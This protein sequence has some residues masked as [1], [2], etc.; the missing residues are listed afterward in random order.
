VLAG[1]C[2]ALHFWAW[3]ASLQHTTVMRS[4]VLVCLTPVW[5]GLI[6]WATGQDR[7][8]PMFWGGITIA[9]LGVVGM[10]GATGHGADPSASLFGDGLAL[11]GGMLAA[12][13]LT[14]GRRVRQG[15]GIGPYGAMVTGACALWLLPA[16]AATGAQLIPPHTTAWLVLAA[17]AFG[18]QLMGHIGF[19]YAVRY[20]SAA[21]VGAVVL[22]EPVGA[23][24]LATLVLDEWPT[25]IETIGAVAIVIGV[26]VATV[27][28]SPRKAKAS[29]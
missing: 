25:V 2:L 9:L 18:P 7:P 26:L 17:M 15:T 8:R 27:P 6:G 28:I 20:V 4:T 3:F 1:L 29:S 21:V 19:N 23:T 24:V 10:S 22:L 14:I 11:L 5:A 13:Y 16:A 12:A